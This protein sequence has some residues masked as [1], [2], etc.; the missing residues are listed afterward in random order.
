MGTTIPSS[1]VALQHRAEVVVEEVVA[2]A[3][4]GCR[5]CLGKAARGQPSDSLPSADGIPVR[6]ALTG[7][8][9]QPRLRNMRWRVRL[10]AIIIPSAIG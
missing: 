8:Y 5:H 1:D 3:L 4:R 2:I 10:S 6:S 9:S 7:C